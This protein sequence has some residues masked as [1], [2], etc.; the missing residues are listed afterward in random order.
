M[1]EN[2]LKFVAFSLIIAA[3]YHVVPRSLRKCVLLVANAVF[4]VSISTLAGGG[5]AFFADIFLSWLLAKLLARNRN[6]IALTVCITLAVLPLVL[7]KYAPF[8]PSTLFAPE[9]LALVA[10]AGISFYTLRIVSCYAD[11]Y[12]GKIDDA[13]GFADYALYVSLFTQIL[14]GPIMRVKDF[15]GQVD[16]AGFDSGRA[17]QGAFLILSGLVKKLVVANMAASYVDSVHARISTLPALC[18]WM[19]A[20]LYA[21]QI[22]A[23]FSGYSDISNGVMLLLGFR[24]TENFSTPYFAQ[25]FG[26]FWRRWHISLSSWLRDYVYIPL[27]GS[28]CSG[29][30]H[31]VNLLA[32]FAVSGLWHGTG[33]NFLFWGLCHGLL[34]WLSSKLK[35]IRNPAITFLLVMLLWIPFRA[36]GMSQALTYYARMF[37]GLSLST[38]AIT[39]MIVLF[40]GDNTCVLYACVLFAGI[41]AMFLHDMAAFMGKDCPFAFTMLFTVMVILFGRMGESAF[42]YA[43]F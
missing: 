37:A 43:R 9:S 20:F 40:T 33:G 3:V 38:S 35:L 29:V 1:A 12:A 42:I 2:I 13:P 17:S 21:V 16:S 39:S 15:T 11:I 10:M 41:L 25:G 34:V 14:S 23:D 31:F 28:R 8:I 24:S 27:G 30:R 6:R 18:L 4:Y 19:G 5:V 36:S 26:D 22:Y 7:T 32:T